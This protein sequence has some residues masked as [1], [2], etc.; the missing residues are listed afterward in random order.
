MGQELQRRGSEVSIA[1]LGDTAEL[2]LQK[3]VM[4]LSRGRYSRL[5]HPH[6]HL[7]E[8]LESSETSHPF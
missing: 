6:Q 4:P 7:R 8:G 5:R 1:S 3:H 2:N